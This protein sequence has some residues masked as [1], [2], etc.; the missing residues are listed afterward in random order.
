MALK[1]MFAW[2]LTIGMVE[3]M[4]E[5]NEGRELY[6]LYVLDEKKNVHVFDYAYEEEIM[7]YIV[8]GEFQYNEAI[9]KEELLTNNK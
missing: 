8:T 5:D 2:L 6:Y 7:N 4:N 1:V 3:P 9:T